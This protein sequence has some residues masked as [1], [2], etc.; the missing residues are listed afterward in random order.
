M[1]VLFGHSVVSDSVTPWTAAHQAS[2]SSTISWSLLK[3]MSIAS[4]MPSNHVILCRP[5]FLLP[6]IFP[7]IR[8]FFNKLALHI[9]WPKEWRFS[10]SISPSLATIN[11]ATM[12]MGVQIPLHNP[13]FNSFGYKPAS[14]TTG[15]YDSSIFKFLRNFHTVFHKICTI[16]KSHHSV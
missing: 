3:L 12:N 10:F 14:G 2:L 6:S 16:L 7:S 13:A 1:L 9:R 11:N 5:L 15:S 4:M 8:V